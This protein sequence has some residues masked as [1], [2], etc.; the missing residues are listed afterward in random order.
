MSSIKFQLRPNPSGTCKIRL[1]FNYG[2]KQVYRYSTKYTISSEKLWDKSKQRMKITKDNINGEEINLELDKLERG[3]ENLIREYER[4]NKKLN[5]SIIKRDLK[6]LNE[7]IKLVN[8]KKQGLIEYFNWFLKYYS[9]NPRPRTH[10]AYKKGTLR[11]IRNSKEKLE[12]FQNQYGYLE[13]ESVTLDFHKNLLNFL[14]KQKLSDNYKGTIIKNLKTVMND[15]YER[16]YHNNLDFKKSG[17]IKPKSEAYNIYLNQKDINKI[18]A[19]DLKEII[20]NPKEYYP[21]GVSIATLDLLNRI[22]DFF[23]IGCHTGLRIQDI[24]SLTSKNIE[25]VKSQ[26]KTFKI[27]SLIP[28]KVDKPVEIPIKKQLEVI[29]N[30]YNG[31]FP[32]K[33]SDVKINKYIKIICKAAELTEIDSHK[34]IPRYQLISSHTARRSFCTNAYKEGMHVLDIMSISGHSSP[35]VFLNYIKATPRDRLNQIKSHP[36]FQ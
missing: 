31:Y 14:N 3:A 9:K 28:E 27:I 15:A 18:T 22:R 8:K 35:E 30:K 7:N 21:K 24:L 32:R 20:D 12:Q 16:D 1:H 4:T 29:L 26:K 2:R 19:L 17:F 23:L 6:K 36:F 10:K 33:V 25:I 5:S 34:K 11:T 13:F